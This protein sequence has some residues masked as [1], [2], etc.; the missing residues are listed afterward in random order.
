MYIYKVEIFLMNTLLTALIPIIAI[1]IFFAVWGKMKALKS[2]AN[3]KR[4]LVSA[5]PTQVKPNDK[6]VLVNCISYPELQSILTGFCNM[7]NQESFQALPQA[8]QLNDREFAITFPYDIEF[9]IFCYFINYLVYPMELESRVDVMAWTTTPKN[10]KWITEESSNKMAMLF[11]P[12]DDREHDN[13][14]MTT[15]DNIGYKL[16]F[17]MGHEKQLPGTP[18]RPFVPPVIKFTELKNREFEDFK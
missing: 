11:I 18:K 16:G 2:K 13:V 9:E 8:I 1:I 14:Y 10:G 17:A 5:L 15:G 6:L 3:K 7:Y 12:E 4:P